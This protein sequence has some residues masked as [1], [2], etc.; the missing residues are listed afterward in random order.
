MIGEQI[1][2]GAECR[3]LD[4]TELEIKAVDIRITVRECGYSVMVLYMDQKKKKANPEEG[5]DR[6]FTSTLTFGFTPNS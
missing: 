2:D 1:I 3:I 4:M 6:C 5:S